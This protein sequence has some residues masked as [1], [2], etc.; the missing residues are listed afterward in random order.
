MRG[1]ILSETDITLPKK[2]KSLGLLW[3]FSREDINFSVR[4]TQLCEL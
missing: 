2:R 3:I 1:E 4:G